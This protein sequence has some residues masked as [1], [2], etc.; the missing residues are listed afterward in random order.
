MA[1]RRS[2]LLLF[3]V[4]LGAALV[5]GCHTSPKA[6][7]HAFSSGEAAG[8]PLGH[9]LR[10]G[11]EHDAALERTGNPY[12]LELAADD[13]G[14]VLLYYGARHSRDRDDPQVAD[15]IEH[16]QA[17]GPTVA[18]C[19]GRQSRH[20]YGFL[21]EPF[22]GLPE[23]TLVHKLARADDVPLVSL[24]PE[25]ADEV[26]T[27]LRRFEPDEVALYFVL[28]GYTS[29]AGGVADEGLAL[30]VIAERLDVDGLRDTLPDLATVDAVWSRVAPPDAGDWRTRT[31]EPRDGRL[32]E[33]SDASRTAR[34]EHMARALLDLVDQG[35]RV[36]AV[37]GSGHVIRQEWALRDALGAEP[38][39]DQ[40]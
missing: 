27:L 26:R 22:A 33:I 30:D 29:E 38:A 39:W 2:A 31:S 32:A 17:F 40:P 20:W 10:N 34:G 16:W 25:Y 5:A 12:V 13:P 24:E 28:R 36:F 23:P 7:P 18:L 4:L 19:E 8:R 37:V 14:G 15:I 11:P 35:E 9:R 3:P 6:P 21:V 1:R